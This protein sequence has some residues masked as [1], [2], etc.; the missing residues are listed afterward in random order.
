MIAQEQ[1]GEESHPVPGQ[2]LLKSAPGLIR[3]ALEPTS[4]EHAAVQSSPNVFCG[5][6]PSN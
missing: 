3:L 6:V 1:M 2:N 5:V 4:A